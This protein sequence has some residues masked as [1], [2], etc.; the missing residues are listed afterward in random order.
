M[1]ALEYPP[2]FAILRRFYELG[3]KYFVVGGV[4][5]VLHGVLRVT[6]DLDVVVDL[7]E[8]NVKKLVGVIEQFNLKPMVPIEPIEMADANKRM[9]W[10]KEKNAKVLNFTDTD[11][12][13][14]LDIVLVYNYFDIKPIE[15]VIDEIPVYVVDKDTLIK[16]KKDAGRDLDLRDIHYLQEL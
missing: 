5:A 15:I 7:G 11:G 13:Y 2:F 9:V 3:V 1:S 6:F 4:A 12:I 14:R 16:M 8:E 10:I